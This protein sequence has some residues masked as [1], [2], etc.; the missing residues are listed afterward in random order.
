[1]EFLTPEKITAVP[2]LP[3]GYA[4]FGDTFAAAGLKTDKKV[5][6]AVWNL[7]GERHV[8]L[9]LPEIDAADIC[10]AYP[11]NLDTH[12]SFDRTSVTVDFSEDEQARIFEITLA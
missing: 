7:G 12:Y 5:Y 1:M 11:R 2:Y 3:K 4:R 8:K 6:L 9:E 10:V